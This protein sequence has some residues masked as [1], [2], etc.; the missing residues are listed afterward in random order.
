M[1]A[2]LPADYGKRLRKSLVHQNDREKSGDSD[3]SKLC[4]AMMNRYERVCQFAYFTTHGPIVWEPAVVLTHRASR[5]LFFPRKPR[6]AEEVG[7][8]RKKGTADEDC[9]F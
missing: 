9:S 1:A 4:L 3:A 6:H 7:M 5:R 2:D 8:P